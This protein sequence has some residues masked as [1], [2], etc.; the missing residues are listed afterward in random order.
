M[1]ILSE[2]K[3]YLRYNEGKLYWADTLRTKRMTSRFGGKIAGD[4][5]KNGY[6]YVSISG[7][8]LLQHRVVYAM[9]HGYW[10][11]E[12][13]HID[14][15]PSN[16][17]IENLRAVNSEINARNKQKRSDNTSGYSGLSELPYGSW[18]VRVGS[19]HVGCYKTK[20]DAIIARSK[21]MSAN[22]YTER[23]GV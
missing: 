18:R 22:Q 8:R 17:K 7:K 19:K 12:I 3:K 20:D 13:D 5:K 15:N 16:N 2:I 10:P 23:H 21:Y 4:V 11:D 9:H 14:G 6:W 1:A